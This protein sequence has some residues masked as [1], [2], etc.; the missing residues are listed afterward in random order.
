[1]DKPTP[2]A[3]KRNPY[4]WQRH[5]FSGARWP[6]SRKARSFLLMVPWI[7]F[8]MMGVILFCLIQQLLMRPG[9]VL[10]LNPDVHE[11]SVFLPEGAQEE[12]LLTRSPTA[13]LRRIV[14]PDRPGV[15]VLLLDDG[16]YCS[17][18]PSEL[19]ALANAYLSKE[20][21]LIVEQDVSYGDTM[22]WIE[23]LKRH[24]VER[25]NLVTA[26]AQPID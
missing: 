6:R 11:Q 13:V 12:G 4:V 25:I 21:N 5:T 10:E 3:E 17:D 18:N 14:A 19:E 1:M 20:L 7:T 9:R 15:T 8:M 24:H 26:H 23:R 22:V 2:E 16:R